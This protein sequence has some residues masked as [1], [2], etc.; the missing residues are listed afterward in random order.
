MSTTSKIHLLLRECLLLVLLSHSKAFHH[1]SIKHHNPVHCLKSSYYPQLTPQKKD[2]KSKTICQMGPSTIAIGGAVISAASAI[3]YVSGSEDRERQE[4]YAE[5]EKAYIEP[6]VAK[7]TEEELKDYDGTSDDHGPILMAVDGDVYNVWKGR[8]LYGPGGIY[9]I[10]AGRDATRLLAK[11]MLEEETEEER[12][13]SL[14]ITDRATLETWKFT[15]M[16]KYEIVGKLD[17]FNSSPTSTGT[18]RR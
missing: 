12:S 5:W 2:R 9:H 3:L 11:S 10:L 16:G 7:W 18:N 4:L 1:P 15:F 14:S 8:Y 17:G 6:R 13:Q